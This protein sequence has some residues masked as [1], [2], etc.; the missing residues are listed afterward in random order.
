LH[1]AVQV[2]AVVRSYVQGLHWV[3]EY[4]YRGVPSWDWFY[5]YHYAPFLSDMRGLEAIECEFE[6]AEPVLPFHQVRAVVSLAHVPCDVMVAVVQ[7]DACVLV[8][9][10]ERLLLPG[11]LLTW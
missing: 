1:S 7:S 6:L 4:Y 10:S 11:I 2:A 9:G 8:S 5:P 3:M